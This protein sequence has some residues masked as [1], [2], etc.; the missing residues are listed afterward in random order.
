MFLIRSSTAPSRFRCCWMNAESPLS[1][2]IIASILA[3]SMPSIPALSL[4]DMMSAEA[5]DE[6]ADVVPNFCSS[7]SRDF[8]CPSECLLH[9]KSS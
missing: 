7:L 9:G 3:R 2:R 8:P 4:A 6:A 5:E 1:R